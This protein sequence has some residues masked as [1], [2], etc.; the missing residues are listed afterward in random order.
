[1]SERDTLLEKTRRQVREGA[2]RIVRQKAI[3]DALD[4]DT[5]YRPQAA[6]A[7]EILASL[8]A[9][10]DALNSRLRAIGTRARG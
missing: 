8:Q 2:L 9:S 10:F 4:G 5:N 3:V 6:L 1:V 7:R